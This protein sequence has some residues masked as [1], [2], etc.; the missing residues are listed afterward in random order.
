M[1]EEF[2]S[3]PEEVKAL[4]KH[5]CMY[6]SSIP[7]QEWEALSSTYI[8]LVDEDKI[9]FDQYLGSFCN[10]MCKS[11]TNMIMSMKF[12]DP[13]EALSSYGSESLSS[14]MDDVFKA[15]NLGLLYGYSL[16]KLMH[17]P[18]IKEGESLL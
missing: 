16:G 1:T 15:L 12:G 11:L 9:P 5:Y 4:L 6:L 17:D 8:G 18:S 7:D 10:S 14:F 2:K 3:T 13:D